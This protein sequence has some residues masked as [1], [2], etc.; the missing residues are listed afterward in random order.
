MIRIRPHLRRSNG[1]RGVD[2]EYG[3][4]STPLRVMDD[5]C[6][7]KYS[8]HMCH[9]QG[10]R[11]DKGVHSCSVARDLCSQCSLRLGILGVENVLEVYI[12]RGERFFPWLWKVGSP[13]DPRKERD[14]VAGKCERV[15][16]S[17]SGIRAQ[18]DRDNEKQYRDLQRKM[19]T[20][21]D[22]P[23][24]IA[25]EDRGKVQYAER[26]QSAAE[27]ERLPIHAGYHTVR[28]QSRTMCS[29]TVETGR[30]GGIIPLTMHVQAIRTRRLVPPSDDLCE[31]ASH[32]SLTPRDGDCIAVSSK[33]VSI[34]EGRCVR[35]ESDVRAQMRRLALEEAQLCHESGPAFQ[36][37]RLWTYTRGVL[38]GRAGIDQSNG[39][40]YLILWPKDPSASA[41]R[42]HAWFCRTYG[43]TR[44]AVIVTDS[45]TLP[46]RRGA[47]GF[48]L[49]WA[50]FDPLVD[51]RGAP[52]LFGRPFAAEHTNLADA[53]AACAVLAM[54]ET[55]ESTP[56]AVIRDVAYLA[57]QIDKEPD[58]EPPYTVNMEEDVFAPFW[59]GVGWRREGGAM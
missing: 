22:P 47:I 33:V 49:G 36:H 5:R 9:E 4:A 35:A 19:R 21:V 59:S 24:K 14:T 25:E 8:L 51:H 1:E 17:L 15:W 29:P 18:R 43:L 11:L 48:A 57:G 54:G 45:C 39:D 42:L 2:H 30:Y 32:S 6:D 31:A 55:D 27:Y 3:A 40:G 26:E 53:L 34:W 52:D 38:I 41:Q 23:G 28:T 12:R 10:I 56:L 44:L 16:S 58:H 7:P 37:P 20:Q 13:Y 50:G 46:L